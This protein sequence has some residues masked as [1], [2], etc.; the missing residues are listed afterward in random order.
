MI[1]Y[2][3][4]I[5]LH[6]SYLRQLIPYERVRDHLAVKVRLM[7]LLLSLPDSS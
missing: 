2:E 5:K 3:A 4:I 1:L 6:I 7:L